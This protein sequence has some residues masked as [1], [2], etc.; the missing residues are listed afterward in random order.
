MVS[1]CAV[2]SFDSH[3]AQS[4]TLRPRHGA[5]SHASAS[6]SEDRAQMRSQLATINQHINSAE[7]FSQRGPDGTIRILVIGR[8]C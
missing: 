5:A 7:S 4:I 2:K 6:S 8:T 3:R 1:V